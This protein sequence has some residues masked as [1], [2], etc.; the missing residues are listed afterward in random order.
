LYRLTPDMPLVRQLVHSKWMT[1]RALFDFLA[2]SSSLSP[3]M[4]LKASSARMRTGEG[5]APSIDM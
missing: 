2:M 3:V 5:L 1:A 4:S